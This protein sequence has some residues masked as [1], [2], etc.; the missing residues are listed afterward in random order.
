MKLKGRMDSIETPKALRLREFERVVDLIDSLCDAYGMGARIPA[1]R[2]LMERF[3][4]SERTVLG[5]LVELQRRGRIIR[6]AGSGTYVASTAQSIMPAG[7]AGTRSN[8]T[9]IIVV[10][11]HDNGYFS[12]AIE[13]TFRLALEMEIE[14]TFE[15]PNF[16]R[17]MS[18]C[19]AQ[20][21]GNYGI[22]VL[23]SQYIFEAR[24]LIDSCS[25]IVGVGD[26]RLAEP[27]PF[28]CVHPDNISGGYLAA[29]HLIQFGHK[30]LAYIMAGNNPR[31]WG[32][33]Q[34]VRHAQLSCLD[35]T[36]ITIG[37]ETFDEWQRKP[38]LGREFFAHP[39]HPTGL[40]VWNDTDAIRLL[41]FLMSIGLN[42][43]DD[44]S[45]VGYDNLPVAQTISPALT[46]VET[47]LEDQVKLAL[48]LLVNRSELPHH[49]IVVE[50]ELI[51]RE[52][53]RPLKSRAGAVI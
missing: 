35:I 5:A 23:G 10:G 48:N 53:T 32:H 43:P 1:H 30:R 16:D 45:I 41:T 19:L 51:V 12:R 47:R 3:N 49:S 20:R 39:E 42:V 11:S 4:S 9:K 34:A 27:N 37:R 24:H 7:V 18:I 44:V 38:S 21:T 14:I 2:D 31:L 29:S 28:G 26:R 25:N 17:L 15:P 46:T 33:E 50:P 6:R 40:C 8:L 36:S 22:L 13:M 52:S